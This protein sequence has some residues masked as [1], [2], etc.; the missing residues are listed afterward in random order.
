MPGDLVTRWSVMISYILMDLRIQGK[1]KCKIRL[2][3][4]LTMKLRRRGFDKMGE[5][6]KEKF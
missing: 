4:I 6:E 1:Q 5:K 3:R 2:S